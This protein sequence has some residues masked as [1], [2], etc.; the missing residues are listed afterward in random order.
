MYQKNSVSWT[1][2]M[3]TQ[4]VNPSHSHDNRMIV[5]NIGGHLL[6]NLNGMN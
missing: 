5:Q 6:M 1:K 3:I 2:L 4:G